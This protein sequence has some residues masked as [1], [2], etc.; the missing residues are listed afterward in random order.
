MKR[1]LGIL[2]G[3]IILSLLLLMLIPTVKPFKD[4]FYLNY[5]DARFYPLPQLYKGDVLS[6][7]FETY[8]EEFYVQVWVGAGEHYILS[9]GF[10]KDE[11]DWIVPKNTTHSFTLVFYNMDERIRAGY[12][13]IYFE[14][15]AEP[16]PEPEPEPKI[17]AFNLFILIAVVSIIVFKEI[18]DIKHKMNKSN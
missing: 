11:G 17:L 6:W 15:N 18:I 10:T 1:K 7:S 5:E 13:D 4:K 2:L 16:E 3:F 9:E 8:N 14:R 12:I